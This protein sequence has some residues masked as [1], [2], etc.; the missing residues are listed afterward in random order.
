MLFSVDPDIFDT[1]NNPRI[2]VTVVKNVN[3]EG[4]NS[5]LEVDMQQLV[6]QI[7]KTYKS[8]T[9]SQEPKIAAWRNAYRLFGAKPSEYPSSIE[10]LYKRIL[11]GQNLG[12][13]NPLV[14]I[15]NYVSVKYMLPAGGEDLDKMRGNLELTCATDNEQAVLVLGK[16]EPEAPLAGEVIYKD[17]LGTIC[18][19]WNWREVERTCLTAKTTN[20]ILVLEA[21]NPVTDQ[22]LRAAQDELAHLVSRYYDSEISNYVV[23]KENKE[24]TW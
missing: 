11:R 6:E 18:R 9:L 19:R 8:E 22:E 1:F 17:D 20:A 15:Y 14:D 13:I 7:R 4:S 21:L 2:A 24:I 23:S 5:S 3:N 10:S 12:S 16:N